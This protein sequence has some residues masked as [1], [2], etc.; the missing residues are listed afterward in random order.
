MEPQWMLSRKQC[1]VSGASVWLY[2]FPPWKSP[3]KESFDCA[4]GA[5]NKN[6]R[7]AVWLHKQRHDR[8]Q[9]CLSH[10]KAQ[11]HKNVEQFENKKI[12]IKQN[13]V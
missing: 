6:K 3:N 13:D 5:Q 11:A 2:L 4:G 1:L 8:T 12:L 9:A 10:Q 7:Q